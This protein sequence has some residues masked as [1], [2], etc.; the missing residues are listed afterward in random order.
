MEQADTLDFL[1]M[2]KGMDV[3]LVLEF[4]LPDLQIAE[5]R[6]CGRR[7]HPKSGRR[8]HVNLNKPIYEGKD[9]VTGEPLVHDPKDTPQVFKRRL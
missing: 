5:D 9:D 1:F 4:S 2:T 6:V 8:Y 7:S 3:D